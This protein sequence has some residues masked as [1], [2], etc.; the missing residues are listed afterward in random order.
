MLQSMRSA[1]KY[2]W[3]ILIVAFVGSFLL[4]E[5]SGLAGRAPVT[6]TTSI[7]TVNGEEILLTTWQ[8]A[9]TALEQE[10]QQQLGSAIT[11]DERQQLEER[12]FNELVTDLLLQQEYKRRGITITDDEILQAARMAPPPQAMQSPDLQTDGQFDMQKYIRLLSSPMA[13]QSGMLA[14]LE[15]Y[16]RNEI[17]KQKLFDQIASGAYISD[18]RLWQVYRDRHDSATVSYV[19]LSTAALTDTAVSVTDAEIS[20]FYERNKKR[21]ER[22]SRAVVSLLTVPRSVTAAD[23]SDAKARIDALRAEIAGGAKFE[24]VATRSSTDSV[25]ALNGGAL[26]RGPKGRF[27]PKFEDAAYALKVGEIS[28]PVLTPFGW[29]IIRVDDKKGDTLDLRHILVTIGQSDSSATRTD[30]RADSLASKAG[31]QE[32]PK[33][34]DE[35]AKMLGLTAAAAV[36]IEKEPLSFAGR[37]VPSVSAWAFSGVRPGET[38]DLFDS[39]DAYYIA[40]LDSLSK[41]GPQPLSAVKEDIRRRLSR[42]KR[43]EKLRPMGEQLAQAAKASSL[44]A[45]AAQRNLQVEKSA[46]FARVDAVPGLGQFTPAIGAAFAA[47]VGQVAG[48]FTALEAMVVMRVDARTEAN[49]QAFEAEKSIQRQQFL[50]SA[51]QQ[52]VDEFLTNL[53]ESVKVDDRRT[54]VLS[55]LRRQSDS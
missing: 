31:S 26:G 39:P 28:Q 33:A 21:F 10:R 24:E 40:R 46:P 51:R 6:T 54:E 18:E 29:H 37:Y 14:G 7:A 30:R 8:N 3:I 49:R 41:G 15:A 38:S 12:A 19:V 27:T 2:I 20:A 42:D 1:A 22:P 11:L 16:Y 55:Q 4:Y 9:V 43:V 45:V 5:T 32:D 53:R 48:P 52:K 50:Q 36:V 47:P 23:S 44:E 13:R 35:A 34:F 17:P 25:S